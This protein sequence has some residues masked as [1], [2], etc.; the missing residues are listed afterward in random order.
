MNFEEAEN[1]CASSEV[2]ETPR[3]GHKSRVMRKNLCKELQ[4]EQRVF[5]AAVPVFLIVA[6][7]GDSRGENTLAV[8]F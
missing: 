2:I 3:E 6:W 8:R 4:I 1:F 7:V 5:V